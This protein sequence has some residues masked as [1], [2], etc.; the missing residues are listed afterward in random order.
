MLGWRGDRV[1]DD[2]E[3]YDWQILVV[4]ADGR[5]LSEHE[6]RRVEGVLAAHRVQAF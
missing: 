2:W 5:E 4:R 1:E 3:I 6:Q